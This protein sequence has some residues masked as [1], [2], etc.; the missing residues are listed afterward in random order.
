MRRGDVLSASHDDVHAASQRYF[1]QAEGIPADGARR[2]VDDAP[3]AGFPVSDEFLHGDRRLVYDR[4]IFQRVRIRLDPI[5]VFEIQ[6][7][8]ERGVLCRIRLPNQA[9]EIDQEMLVRQGD[10]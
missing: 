7:L 9:A 6:F 1:P 5:E 10:A 4:V 8:V 2:H 3:A